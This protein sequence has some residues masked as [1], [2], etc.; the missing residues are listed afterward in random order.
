MVFLKQSLSAAATR[1]S[2]LEA[3]HGQCSCCAASSHRIN[4]TDMSD[5]KVF[6]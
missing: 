3:K 5:A 6:S 1:S 2:N 4:V